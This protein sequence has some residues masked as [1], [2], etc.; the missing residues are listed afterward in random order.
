MQ[1]IHITFTSINLSFQ[2]LEQTP[3]YTN[4]SVNVYDE[5]YVTFI[6]IDIMRSYL[7]IHSSMINK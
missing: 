3:L 5:M 2:I 4:I 1:N 6:Y 7:R